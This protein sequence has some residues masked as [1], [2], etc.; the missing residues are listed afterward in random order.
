MAIFIRN[1]TPTSSNKDLATPYEV[2]HGQKP[3]LSRLPRFGGRSLIH[4]PD[5]LRGKLDG[6]AVEGIFLGFA[7]GM[8]AG[9]IR[10]VGSNASSNYI[11]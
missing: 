6:K 2:L 3:D 7:D 4:I 10:D 8:K 9:V 1:R 5:Q 11:T